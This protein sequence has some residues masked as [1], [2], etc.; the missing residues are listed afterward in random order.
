[1]KGPLP[2]KNPYDVLRAKEQELI[3]VRKEMDAL[4]IAAKLLGAEDKKLSGSNEGQPL[5]RV[6]EM[7]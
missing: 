3:K 6:V 5:T 1:M 7:P 4:R 2:M